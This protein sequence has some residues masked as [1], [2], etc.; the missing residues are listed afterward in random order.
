M[1]FDE[2]NENNYL[3]FAIKYYENPQAATQE[4]FLEDMKRFKYVKRLLRKYK[5]TGELNTH[6]LINHF[7]I[8]YNIFGDA[9]TPLLFFKLERDL[10]GV[11][12]TFMVF[13]QRFPEYPKSILHD[14]DIDDTCMHQ[15]L[16]L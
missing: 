5:N 8:L 2:L 12:K 15:L 4:D 11:V 3:M 1:K 10:W 16:K 7:I 14:V 9:A 6:L 13:L